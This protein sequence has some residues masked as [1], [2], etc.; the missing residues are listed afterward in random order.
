M[1]TPTHRTLADATHTPASG[2]FRETTLIPKGTTG[3]IECLGVDLIGQHQVMF[4][5]NAAR[6]LIDRR[7]SVPICRIDWPVER[8]AEALTMPALPTTREFDRRARDREFAEAAM[9][10]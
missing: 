5:C 4:I 3:V 10:G 6:W 1:T 8:E 7:Y 9:R 2:S